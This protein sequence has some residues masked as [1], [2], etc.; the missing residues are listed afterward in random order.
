MELKQIDC[1][2]HPEVIRWG[3]VASLPQSVLLIWL[4]VGKN[5]FLQLQSVHCSFLNSNMIERISAAGYC[6]HAF[7]VTWDLIV[8]PSVCVL[9]KLH[10][11][12]ARTPGLALPL[13]PF[14]FIELSVLPREPFFST[15][16]IHDEHRL[17]SRGWFNF[18][19]P[20]CVFLLWLP[21]TSPPRRSPVM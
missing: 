10:R 4:Y 2:S 3:H 20:H 1:P 16:G 9:N 8:C 19:P 21:P 7:C 14:V 15:A 18:P 12:S 5:N 11:L 17:E 13:F 6:T